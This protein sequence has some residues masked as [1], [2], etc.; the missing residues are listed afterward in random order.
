MPSFMAAT[1]VAHRTAD[2]S[3]NPRAVTPHHAY[4]DIRNT[5]NNRHPTQSKAPS[6]T[7]RIPRH[8]QHT[9]YHPIPQRFDAVHSTVH[10]ATYGA[11]RTPVTTIPAPAHLRPRA[12]PSD[13]HGVLYP[14]TRAVHSIRY[15]QAPCGNRYPTPARI[16]LPQ[17]PKRGWP[18]RNQSTPPGP[19]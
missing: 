1:Y 18:R 10:A 7:P 3:P 17:S 11:R 8:T 14:I 13:T 9:G 15:P 19:P 4:P 6:T 16:A 2:I 12:H 5:Q